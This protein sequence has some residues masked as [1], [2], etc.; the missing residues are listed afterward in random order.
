MGTS[1]TDRYKAAVAADDTELI[2]QLEID[3]W[4][5]SYIRACEFVSPNSPSF[6][7]LRGSIYQSLLS[8]S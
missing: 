2:D 7:A 4:A 8:Q 3:A 6:G 5:E 1:F